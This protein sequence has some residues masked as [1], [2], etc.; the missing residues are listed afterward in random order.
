M[1][2]KNNSSILSFIENFGNKSPNPTMLFIYLPIY[3][4]NNIVCIRK[5]GCWRKLSGHQRWTNITA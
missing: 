1:N 3:Y 2:K 5:D 4:D